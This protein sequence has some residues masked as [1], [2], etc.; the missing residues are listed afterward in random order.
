MSTNM[1]IVRKAYAKLP[2]TGI[3]KSFSITHPHI[4]AT[5]VVIAAFAGMFLASGTTNSYGVYEEE[6]ENKYS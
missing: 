2:R 6:Y 4:T 1:S 3:S 5:M